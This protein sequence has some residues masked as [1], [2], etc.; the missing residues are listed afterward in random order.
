LL[1]PQPITREQW[2][3]IK[4]DTSPAWSHHG[5]SVAFTD[6][7]SFLF[8]PKPDAFRWLSG[9]WDAAY[10]D[11]PADALIIAKGTQLFKWRGSS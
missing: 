7:H 2:Q 3:Q 5:P 1:T 6:P 10:T 11:M 9:R 8:H 4:P